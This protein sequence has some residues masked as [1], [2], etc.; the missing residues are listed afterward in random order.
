[1]VDRILFI[2]PFGF[3]Y[4]SPMSSNER[5]SCD[6]NGCDLGYDGCGNSRAKTGN[7]GIEESIGG[8]R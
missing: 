3:H 8:F 6:K 1:M 4:L 2:I 5:I 7:I